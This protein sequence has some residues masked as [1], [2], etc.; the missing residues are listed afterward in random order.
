VTYHVSWQGFSFFS[1]QATSEDEEEVQVL[2]MPRYFLSASCCSAIVWR[3]CRAA[4]WAAMIPSVWVSCPSTFFKVA[5]RFSLRP[6]SPQ[7]DC[8]APG[9]L[10]SPTTALPPL[11][12]SL[13]T[14]PLCSRA[15]PGNP[16][17]PPVQL[18]SLSIDVVA[19]SDYMG[20]CT[21]S[22]I[23]ITVSPRTNAA[24]KVPAYPCRLHTA[25]CLLR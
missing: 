14:K 11:H 8:Q 4:S 25:P 2:E 17:T 7:F 3:A 21:R 1:H 6:S 24:R 22:H 5:Q 18:L 15:E 19:P 20:K 9:H 10:G 16:T 12:P 13:T 23:P